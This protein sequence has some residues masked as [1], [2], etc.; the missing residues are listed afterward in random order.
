MDSQSFLDHSDEI[1][2]AVQQAL[3]GSHSLNDVIS[4][5]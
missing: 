4:D 2:K 5:L 3:L 1:A